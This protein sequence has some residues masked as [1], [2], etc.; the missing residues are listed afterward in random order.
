MSRHFR[1]SCNV[2]VCVGTNCIGHTSVLGGGGG[3]LT[4]TGSGD[5]VTGG[6]TRH[7]TVTRL[8]TR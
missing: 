5:T 7:N 2:H 3:G 8:G 4:G 1:C 6:D